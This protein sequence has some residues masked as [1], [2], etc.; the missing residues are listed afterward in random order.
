MEFRSSFPGECKEEIDSLQAHMEATSLCFRAGKSPDFTGNIWKLIGQVSWTDFLKS[1]DFRAMQVKSGSTW[2]QFSRQKRLE[3]EWPEWG[4][5]EHHFESLYPYSNF[6]NFW[7]RGARSLKPSNIFFVPMVF[8]WWCGR[9]LVDATS[10]LK[11][12]LPTLGSDPFYFG[13]CN[14]CCCCWHSKRCCRSPLWCL[15]ST[16]VFLN[17][18]KSWFWT[19]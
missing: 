3:L 8:C 6:Q 14:K 13:W 10:L 15:Q 1:M 5:V 9:K 17:V 18:L 11:K 7:F 4:L 16:F 2:L 12:S 19:F